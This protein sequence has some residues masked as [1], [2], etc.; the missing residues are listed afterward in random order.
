MQINRL[1]E[2]IYILLNKKSIT[3][4]ELAERFEV[5][6]RTI[7]RD[8]DTL[9]SAGI[10]IYASQGKGGGISLLDD[11]VLNKS[12]LSEREQNEIL[13]A[14]QSLS[15]TLTPETD[16]VLARLSSLFNRNTTNWIEVDFSPW[17]SNEKGTCQFTMIKNA[18]LSRQIIEFN[19][20]GSSGEKSI[21]KVEPVKLIFKV[22]AWYLQAFCLTRNTYRTFKITRMSDL[23]MTPESF[24]ER[25]FEGIKENEQAQ[26]TQIDVCLNISAEGAYRVYDEFDEE[27]ITKNNDGSYMVKASLPRG[28]WIYNYLFSYGP[29]LEVIEPKELR[30]EMKNRIK[31]MT[32]KY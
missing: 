10:P 26:T 20:F 29:L 21:R 25:D 15:I 6:V 18:I 28:D 17:G 11:Y 7:Y 5:S 4:K 12:V 24:S 1:F 8:I 19:Y 13:Y 32:N 14:L 23:Q 3:A 9:S 30:R 22:N 31:V 2:I 16:K 27:D